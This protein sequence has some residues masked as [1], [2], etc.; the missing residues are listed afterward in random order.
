MPQVISTIGLIL[1]I[2]LVAATVVVILTDST[3][4]SSKITWILVIALLPVLGLI[5]YLIM[6]I[7]Y[8]SSEQVFVPS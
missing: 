4:A 8:E 7:N 1:F 2:I 5:L 6:G 3:R